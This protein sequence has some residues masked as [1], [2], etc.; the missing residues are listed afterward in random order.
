MLGDSANSDPSDVRPIGST[1]IKLL[2]AIIG[3]FAFQL[4]STLHITSLT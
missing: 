2:H 3:L 4:L 1:R